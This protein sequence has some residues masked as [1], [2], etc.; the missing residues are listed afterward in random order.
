MKLNIALDGPSGAGKSTFA[1]YIASQ[2]D[3]LYLDTG[4]MYR[5]V[6]WYVIAK[7][8]EPNDKKA[9][10]AVLDNIDIDI[11]YHNREQRV[12]VCG[13]DVSN[14][15]RE[16]N[17]SMAASTVSKIAEVRLKLVE[18]QRKIAQE[19]DC[20]LDGRDIGSFVLPNAQIKIFLTADAKERARRRYLELIEKGN[21]ISYG[22]VLSEVVARDKQ[23]TT[24]DFAPLV[25]AKDAIIIDT[26]HFSIEETKKEF[27]KI[28]CKLKQQAL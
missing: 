12:L 16:N 20:V 18:L 2:L 25:I 26:T 23:D 21:S 6:A 4:A 27:D 14:Y 28:I 7:G 3:I 1:K 13:K 11:K 5:G 9:I 8:I 15:I 19:N 22:Q 10:L 24:R 17:I